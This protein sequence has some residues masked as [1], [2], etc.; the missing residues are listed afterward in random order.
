MH[1]RGGSAYSLL[2][3]HIHI[4]III[5]IISISIKISIRREG[6]AYFLLYPW[7]DRP[8]LV[9]HVQNIR[10][11]TR[12]KLWSFPRIFWLQTSPA[13]WV[14]NPRAIH[15]SRFWAHPLL[16]CMTWYE[17]GQC[18]PWFEYMTYDDLLTLISGRFCTQLTCCLEGLVGEE[19]GNLM[20]NLVNPS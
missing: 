17:F 10:R 15:L 4:S 19:Y 8:V 9:N 20:R 18:R 6:Q 3:P 7:A 2:H 5:S 1:K 13:V 16:S 12:I 11:R 14:P